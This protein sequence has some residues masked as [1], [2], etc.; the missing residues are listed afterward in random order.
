MLFLE[1]SL[2]LVNL[3][4]NVRGICALRSWLSLVN[5]FSPK[6]LGTLIEGVTNLECSRCPRSGPLDRLEGII[7]VSAGGLGAQVFNIPSFSQ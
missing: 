2:V 6:R 4:A 3:G 5:I 7:F 1:H